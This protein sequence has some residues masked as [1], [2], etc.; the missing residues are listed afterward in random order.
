MVVSIPHR[1][2]KNGHNAQTKRRKAN[3]FQFLIGTLK[4]PQSTY[5]KRPDRIVSI[6]HR[7]AKNQAL[8]PPLEEFPKF[9]FLIGTLKTRARFG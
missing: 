8:A 7:Y 4:T 5:P 6:P 2:A 9:Q 3:E 1:Y